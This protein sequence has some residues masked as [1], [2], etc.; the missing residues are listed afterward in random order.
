MIMRKAKQQE[1][2]QSLFIEYKTVNVAKDTD[3][4]EKFN[5]IIQKYRV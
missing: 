2:S 4:L 1:S 3:Y 5:T